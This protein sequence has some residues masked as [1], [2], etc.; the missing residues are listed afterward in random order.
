MLQNVPPDFSPNIRA[1]KSKD[2]MG[3]A[4]NTHGK[5]KK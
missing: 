1:I 5:D 2:E 3:G 4:C